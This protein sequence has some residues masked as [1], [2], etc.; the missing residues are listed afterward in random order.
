MPST[1]NTKDSCYTKIVAIF[2]QITFKIFYLNIQN[3]YRTGKEYLEWLEKFKKTN[4]DFPKRSES[5][6]QLK[7]LKNKPKKS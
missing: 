1:C 4:T 6:A 7:R 3:L 5:I 2:K